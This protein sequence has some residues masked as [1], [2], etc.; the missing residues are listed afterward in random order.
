[1]P[2]LIMALAQTPAGR[3]QTPIRLPPGMIM[4]GYE[5]LAHL[6]TGW[7]GS[8]YHASETRTG[9]QRVIKFYRVRSSLE[10]RWLARAARRY[11]AM[12]WTGAVAR[13]HHCG[14]LLRPRGYPLLYIVF[15]YLDGPLLEPLLA[16]RWR[17]TPNVPLTASTLLIRLIQMLGKF[18]QAGFAAGDIQRG[19]NL[20]MVDGQ[21]PRIF[22]PDVHDA[23]PNC[24]Y[25]YDLFHLERIGARLM[26]NGSRCP[27]LRS[28]IDL[29]RD[30]LVGR[31]GRDAAARLALD[32]GP[33]G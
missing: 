18:H 3:L 12:S 25:G 13:Y 15:D 4:D 32:L 7:E 8:V 22:D 16:K 24:N 1:M 19:H 9:I 14:E 11:E 23:R 2:I 31:V 27:A 17:R 28:T 6:G 26:R 10:I 29:L 21:H 5:L 30:R 33:E 20:I